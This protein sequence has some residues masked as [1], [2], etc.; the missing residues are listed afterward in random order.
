MPRSKVGQRVAVLSAD[1]RSF[2]GF[3]S[4]AGDLPCPLLPRRQDGS[5]FP[6]PKL[7]LDSGEVKWGFETW[8]M[9]QEEFEAICS[10]SEQG[11]EWLQTV[12]KQW[13]EDQKDIREALAN[14]QKGVAVNNGN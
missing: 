1:G 5:D 10:E 6:N 3:G 4:Y 8:W 11:M 14:A 2:L 9:P 7:I 13:A 12:K